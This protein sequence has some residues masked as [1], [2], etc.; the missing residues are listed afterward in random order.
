MPW[1]VEDVDKHKKGLTPAQK[2]QWVK[3]ANGVLKSCKTGGESD[4]EGKAIRVANSKFALDEAI[5]SF[6]TTVPLAAL[7]FSDEETFAKVLP[8]TESEQ[9]RLE[10][11]CYSGGVI[12]DHWY[13]GDLALDLSGMKIKGN[14]FPILEDHDTSKKIAFTKKPLVDSNRLIIDPDHVVFMDT[15]ESIEFRENSRKGFPYQASI[16]GTPTKVAR[17]MEGEEAEVNGFTMK[18][19][20]SI[21]REW[22]YK[23]TSVCVF[24]WDENTSSKV[25]KADNEV[26]V[27]FEIESKLVAHNDGNKDVNLK[28]D[29][30]KMTLEELKKDHPDLVTLLS[31]ETKTEIDSKFAQER[32][33]FKK[34][35]EGLAKENEILKHE[36][37]VLKDKIDK[38]S[39]ET[40]KTKAESIVA[41][42][43]SGS[44][45]P[46]ELFGKVK[47]YL[48]FGSFVKDGMLDE[49]GFAKKVSEEIADWEDKL[50]SV[51]VM[52]TGTTSKTTTSATGDEAVDEDLVSRMAKYVN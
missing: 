35:E 47:A 52:G 37:S 13:W 6:T 11:V 19:P 49:E 18:G 1:S 27:D 26:E 40:A 29:K 51:S 12:K 33:D 48:S 20:S 32:D 4:C 14:K 9:D 2:T 41:E 10:M 7:E 15:P 44:S 24:G 22:A 25:F 3:I 21:W 5:G 46:Q 36:N 39:A 28:G 45:V 42:K 17:L 30:K 38:F 31:I 50:K 34:R 8:K 16:R 23:E 43:L